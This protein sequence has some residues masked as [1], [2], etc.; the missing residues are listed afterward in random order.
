[1]KLL[2]SVDQ[3]N[4]NVSML[5]M[6]N[7]PHYKILKIPSNGTRAHCPL[8]SYCTPLYQA[9][10]NIIQITFDINISPVGHKTPTLLYF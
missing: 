8:S 9:T 4:L 6:P 10:I 2:T 5:V 7:T 1:M 3:I